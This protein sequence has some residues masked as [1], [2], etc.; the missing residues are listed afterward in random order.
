M[1]WKPAHV[2][3]ARQTN[4]MDSLSFFISFTI[5]IASYF[6]IGYVAESILAISKLPPWYRMAWVSGPM[7]LSN[8]IYLLIKTYYSSTS[9]RHDRHP[10][11]KEHDINLNIEF[12]VQRWKFSMWY[13]FRLTPNHKFVKHKTPLL[14]FMKFSLL[15]LSL[16]GKFSKHNGMRKPLLKATIIQSISQVMTLN[17]ISVASEYILLNHGEDKQWLLCH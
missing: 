5:C 10:Q 8:H 1:T 7:R 9:F 13:T 15:I 3:M 16:V 12:L 2:K 6:I 4:G 14:S 17:N 11:L